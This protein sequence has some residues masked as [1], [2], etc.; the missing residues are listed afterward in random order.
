MGAEPRRRGAPVASTP[1]RSGA[2]PCTAPIRVARRCA[3][4]L[5]RNSPSGEFRGRSPPRTPSQPPGWYPEWAVGRGCGAVSGARNRVSG[6][7]LRP[8]RASPMPAPCQ[9]RR[10]GR[11]PPG[12]VA[13]PLCRARRCCVSRRSTPRAP[14]I[15]RPGPSVSGRRRVRRCGAARRPRGPIA[16]PAE[17]RLRRRD[18]RCRPVHAPGCGSRVGPRRGERRGPHARCAVHARCPALQDKT[19]QVMHRYG[20][21]P[22]RRCPRPASGLMGRRGRAAR[23]PRSGGWHGAADQATRCL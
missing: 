17:M 3:E 8:R 4:S 5:T 11:V 6:R 9:A 18:G 21:R 20:R 10:C 19:G 1:V 14:S 13:R 23:R 15:V 12:T 7:A 16:G 22:P 2:R